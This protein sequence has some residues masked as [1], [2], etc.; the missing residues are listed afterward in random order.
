MARFKEKY[1]GE[2][3]AGYVLVEE[4]SRPEI[5]STKL[6]KNGNVV[7]DARLNGVTLPQFDSSGVVSKISGKNPLEASEIIKSQMGVSKVQIVATPKLFQ[8]V[9]DKFLPWKAENISIETVS[10]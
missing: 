5:K 10:D 9:I 3:P 1:G 8:F 7:I 6:D 4:I 2:I